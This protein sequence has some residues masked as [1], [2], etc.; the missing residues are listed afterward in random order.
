MWSLYFKR[1]FMRGRTAEIFGPDMVP[2][3]LEVRN[4]GYRQM[5]Q[6]NK[7]ET[8]PETVKLLQAYADGINSYAK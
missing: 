1:M 4:I 3:D 7:N 5:G 2:T 6:M 8:D